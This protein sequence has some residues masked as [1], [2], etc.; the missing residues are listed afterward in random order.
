MS[1]LNQ[2]SLLTYIGIKPPLLTIKKGDGSKEHF[3]RRFGRFGSWGW[4]WWRRWLGFKSCLLGLLP[5]LGLFLL[6]FLFF[7]QA[8]LFF[9]LSF[10][11]FFRRFYWSIW[12][13]WLLYITALIINLVSLS[14]RLLYAKDNKYLTL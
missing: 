11:I 1:K 9:L 3:A 4:F 6:A 2:N 14:W 5:F 12:V 7:L 8:F 13:K 10:L